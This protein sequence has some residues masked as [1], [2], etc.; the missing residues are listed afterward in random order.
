MKTL[1]K[2][3][4]V[5]ILLVVIALAA[6]VMYLDVL[7][8]AGVERVGP[9]ITGTTVK[10]ES[11]TLSLLSGQGRIKG[12]D[13]GNPPGFQTARAFKLTDAKVKVDLK[14]ALSDKLIIE[15][16][17][18][19]GPEITYEAASSGSNLAKL[20]T[21]VTA[22]GK[23]E[24]AKEPAPAQKK[25]GAQRKIQI[26]DFVL[27]NAVVNASAPQLM[28][29]SHPIPLPDIHLR[30][31]GKGPEGV[32]AQG[33]AAQVLTAVN[34][35][36]LQAVASSGKFLNEGVKAAQD[37]AKRLGGDAGKSVDDLTKGLFGK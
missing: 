23:S 26:N 22:F 24:G 30:D 13:I 19:D 10:V 27:K 20:Q 12:L 7:I 17:L 28:Q 36:A 35:A 4:A 14:S 18:I 5:I 2:I 37:A 34:V 29:G 11:V 3:G 21:N 32:T 25:M 31:M 6:A 15:E 33:A 9:E 16:I 1:L 8:K